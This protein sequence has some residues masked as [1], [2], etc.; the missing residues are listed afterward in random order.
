MVSGQGSLFDQGTEV[1]T[2][3]LGRSLERTA[4]GDGAWLDI[5]REWIAGSSVLFDRLVAAVP[6]RADRRRMYDREVDV[7]RLLRGEAL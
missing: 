4:L 5:R 7:P 3:P 1:G 6:W 2:R